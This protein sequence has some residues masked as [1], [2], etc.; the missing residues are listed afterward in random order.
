VVEA[1]AKF[2]SLEQE[3]LGLLSKSIERGRQMLS[4]ATAPAR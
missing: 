1:F 3:L 4:H 2:V